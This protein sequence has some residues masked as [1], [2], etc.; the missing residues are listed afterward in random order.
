M[1]SKTM[2]KVRGVGFEPQSGG[3]VTRTLPLFP[4]RK[5]LENQISANTKV[6]V[7]I[8]LFTQVKNPVNGA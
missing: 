7:H 8:F 3:D 1:A 2:L 4:F 6:V 5:H